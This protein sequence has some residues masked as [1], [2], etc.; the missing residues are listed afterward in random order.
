MRYWAQTLV[1]FASNQSFAVELFLDGAAR[2]AP[3]DWPLM[4]ARTLAWLAAGGMDPAVPRFVNLSSASILA[5]DDQQV[6]AAA[7][8]GPLIIDWSDQGIDSLHLMWPAAHRLKAWRQ[9]YGLQVSVDNL[10]DP[11]G[12][13]KVLLSQADLVKLDGPF[14][15]G[16][17]QNERHAS[18]IR[19]LGEWCGSQGIRF[20]A[21]QLERDEDLIVARAM[22][23]VA[24]QGYLFDAHTPR[25]CLEA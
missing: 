15:L 24:G 22:G 9:H 4:D 16:A 21:E 1:D 12:I 8:A 6:A 23:C 19:H 2:V 14:L 25:Q 11:G 10:G 7:A 3:D 5:Q 18:L 20:I 13:Q 17:A